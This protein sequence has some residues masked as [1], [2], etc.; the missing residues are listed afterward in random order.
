MSLSS[1]QLR[2]LSPVSSTEVLKEAPA[3]NVPSVGDHIFYQDYPF[4]AE[5]T[6]W[7][8][9]TEDNTPLDKLVESLII[10]IDY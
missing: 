9:F 7:L 3:L 10:G 4:A 2:L 6:A 1:S 5:E 8:I